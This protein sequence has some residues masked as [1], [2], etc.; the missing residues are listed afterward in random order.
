MSNAN[1][2]H[3]QAHGIAGA[4]EPGFIYQAA[5]VGPHHAPVGSPYRVIDVNVDLVGGTK[6]NLI[7]LGDAIPPGCIITAVT[8]NGQNSLEDGVIVTVGL[9][10]AVLPSTVPTVFTLVQAGTAAA[11]PGVPG[12][13]LNG[14]Q[15]FAAV[16][17]PVPDP[18]VPGQLLFPVLELTDPITT[19][20]VAGS[21]RVKIVYFC[22]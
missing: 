8:M 10:E 3:I 2:T 1:Y 22:P 9:G 18:S 5:T 21:V 16:N 14:G 7:V 15:V 17:S 13:D 6:P 12:A 19:P 11:V 4:F 20:M